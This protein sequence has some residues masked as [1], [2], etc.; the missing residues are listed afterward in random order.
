LVHP[1]FAAKQ[2]VTVDHVSRGRFGV[3][4]V[5]GWNQ[6]EFDMFGVSQRRA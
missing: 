3:N 2:F 4:V 1:V 5:C 6:D